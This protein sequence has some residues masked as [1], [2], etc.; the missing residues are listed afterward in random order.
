[1]SQEIKSNGVLLMLAGAA[2]AG[3]VAVICWFVFAGEQQTVPQQPQVIRVEV[4]K[5]FSPYDLIFPP[6]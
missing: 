4:E 3:V 6:K 5:K 2:I 1:M